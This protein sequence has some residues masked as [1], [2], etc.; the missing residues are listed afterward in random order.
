LRKVLVHARAAGVDDAVDIG[1]GDI[2]FLQ[3]HRHQQVD[4]GERGR[5]GAG[6]DE[7]YLFEPL[8][9]Q[10]QP[11]A[12]GRGDDDGGAVLVV[13][14]DGDFHPPAQFR[15]DAKAFGRLDVF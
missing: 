15:L 12:D 10:Y 4:A 3:T 8:A 9:L 13:M 2:L 11:V 7:L 14:E 1:N 5:A 6:G